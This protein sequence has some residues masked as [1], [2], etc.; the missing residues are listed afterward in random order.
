MNKSEEALLRAFARKYSP[1]K[2]KMMS[3]EPGKLIRFALSDRYVTFVPDGKGGIRETKKKKK[4][5]AK[6]EAHPEGIR[7]KER[8]DFKT[9]GVLKEITRQL[10]CEAGV[11]AKNKPETQK[12][13][14]STKDEGAF[15]PAAN[16]QP[17]VDDVLKAKTPRMAF[18]FAPGDRV[19]I[20]AD[21]EGRVFTV[22][23]VRWSVSGTEYV[24]RNGKYERL[25]VCGGDLMKVKGGIR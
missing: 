20:S 18:P 15:K 3:Y 19:E 17:D 12:S 9:D 25:T 7:A 14:K 11:S 13:V 6:Y 2:V 21:T 10:G 5:V 22:Q 23:E 16:R 8:D 1:S 4:G 24:V